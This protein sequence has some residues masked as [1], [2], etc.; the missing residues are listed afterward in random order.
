MFEVHGLLSVYLMYDLTPH[1]DSV[2][3]LNVG[4]AAEPTLLT[5]FQRKT[6]EHIGERVHA[7]AH[8]V[9]YDGG[10]RSDAVFVVIEG[11]L[12]SYRKLPSGKRVTSTFLFRHDIFG[13]AERGRYL[14][15]VQAVTPVTLHQLPLAELVPLIKRDPRLQFK[16]LMKVTQALREA[17]RRAILIGRHDA[18]GRMAMF[19]MMMRRQHRLTVGHDYDVPLP[20]S[21]SDIASF[22][23]L[24]SE[25]VSRAARGLQQRGLV[26]FESRHL[27]RIL[28]PST[29]AKLAAAV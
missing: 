6:L 23:N 8:A 25:S 28:N 26:V 4:S 14:N 13:L 19:L 3:F 2:P 10:D 22:L 24:T 5:D 21:R 9:I 7:R 29:L 15:S 12:K 1:I 11:V 18:I 16:F 17:Q 20:M 27:A